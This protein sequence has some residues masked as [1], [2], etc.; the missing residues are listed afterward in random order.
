MALGWICF[1]RT[2]A[3]GG[4]ILAQPVC[5]YYDW[6]RK[7][8]RNI[9]Q[10][11][12][13]FVIM[14]LCVLL[15]GCATQ[16]GISAGNKKFAENKYD[17][18]IAEFQNVLKG[19][20]DD[21]K[22]LSMLGWSYFKKADYENAI[23]TFK[24]YQKLYP[25]EPESYNGLGWCYFK[26][27]DFE[28]AKKSFNNS[29]KL[30]EKQLDPYD[31]LGWIYITSGELVAAYNKF[32][33]AL[34]VNIDDPEAHRGL[35]NYYFTMQEYDNSIEEMRLALRIQ[36][37]WS[38]CILI[39]AKNYLAKQKFDVAESFFE[40]YL[41]KKPYDLD[42]SI[43]LAGMKL[44]KKKYNKVKEYLGWIPNKKIEKQK[45]WGNYSAGLSMLGWSYFY[46]KDYKESLKIFKLLAE[47]HSESDYFADVH[48]GLAWNYLRLND[49]DESFME[50][51]LALKLAPGYNSSLAGLAELEKV[52]SEKK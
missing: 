44:Y 9:P 35:G 13:N 22:A 29:I 5:K 20:P 32:Q 23:K 7:V 41:E 28:K 6:F 17:S 49:F 21:S 24:K 16:T 47:L 18:A 14:L 11:C 42:I 12:H 39:T 1:S 2:F 50:F 10:P 26:T 36:P 38:D 33:K 31:G 45:I 15:S 40:D 27:G 34:S 3:S 46:T 25:E 4:R 48:D 43:Q 8:V 37:D 51:Q 19:S 30:N 52:K